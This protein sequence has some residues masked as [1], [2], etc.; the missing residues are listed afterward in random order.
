[1]NDAVVEGD[2][3]VCELCCYYTDRYNVKC[4]KLCGGLV[5]LIIVVILLNVT[6]LAFAIS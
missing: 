6:K 3:V 2:V 1:M 5:I 4:Q